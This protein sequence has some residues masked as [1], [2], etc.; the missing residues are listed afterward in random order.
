MQ[1]LRLSGQ[2]P[3]ELLVCRRDVK[4]LRDLRPEHLPLLR[5]I[6]MKG[7]QVT[8]SDSLL[9]LKNPQN[10]YLRLAENHVLGVSVFIFQYY[11]YR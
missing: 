11:A 5:N 9:S 4:S 2:K 6:L 1:K 8:K 10:L 7:V 3:H